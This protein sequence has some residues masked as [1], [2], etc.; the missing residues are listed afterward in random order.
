MGLLVLAFTTLLIGIV[1]SDV[2]GDSVEGTEV[3]ETKLNESI[4]ISS[5]DNTITNE[6]IAT[7]TSGR[8]RVVRGPITGVSFFGNQSNNTNLASVS[9]GTHVNFTKDGEIIISQTHF[10]GTGPY[11]VSYVFT[12][13][14]KGSVVE[15]DVRSVTQFSNATIGTE[16]TGIDVDTEVNFTLAGDITVSGYNFSDGNYNISYTHDG[17]LFVSNST[18]RTFLG[19]IP[20]FFIIALVIG[21]ILFMRRMFPDIFAR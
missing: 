2:I 15:K 16:I 13:N 5:T 6:T 11:N 7:F 21:A 17:E 1:F 14:S 9:L 19:L 20:I 12:T 4:A 10:D 18:A 8:G 3:V